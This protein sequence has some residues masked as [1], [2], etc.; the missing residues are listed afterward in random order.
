MFE[1]SPRRS[2]GSLGDYHSPKILVYK[3]HFPQNSSS[4]KIRGAVHGRIGLVFLKDESLNQQIIITLFIFIF[5]FSE[6]NNSSFNFRITSYIF[7]LDLYCTVIFF[8]LSLNIMVFENLQ[9]IQIYFWLKYK[10]SLS[11]VTTSVKTSFL[12][13]FTWDYEHTRIN[14]VP[15]CLFRQY[16]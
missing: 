6:F 1:S 5:T 11:F 16:P 12:P 14:V 2:F 13:I 8:Y 10:A 4:T 3:Q 7:L 9:K 15:C